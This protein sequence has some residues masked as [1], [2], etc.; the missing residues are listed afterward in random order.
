MCTMIGIRRHRPD[1]NPIAAQLVGDQNPRLAVLLDE[2]PEEALRSPC[3]AAL[4]DKNVEHIAIG[5]YGSPQ[6]V[7]FAVDL[8]NDFIQVPFVPWRRSVA[9]DASGKMTAE[10]ID[11]LP[12]RLTADRHTALRKQVFDIGGAQGK[13]IVR[14]H[15]IADDFTWV[16]VAFQGWQRRQSLHRCQL[17][18]N[19]P[20]FNLAIPAKDY[21]Y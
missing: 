4:L 18:A 19:A 20:E 10:T 12:H 8:D 3:I 17:K 15:R 2:T 14:P 7:H 13:S 16:T 5:I 11:P 9:T 21:G 6:P 1:R